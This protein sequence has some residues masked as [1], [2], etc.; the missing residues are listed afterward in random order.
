MAFCDFVL[1][2]SSADSIL[3]GHQSPV[4]V[5]FWGIAMVS[6]VLLAVVLLL[7]V[8]V[9][10]TPW[11]YTDLSIPEQPANDAGFEAHERARQLAAHRAEAEFWNQ[12]ALEA[13]DEETRAVADNLAVHHQMR[14]KILTFQ[15]EDDNPRRPARHGH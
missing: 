2:I 3:D 1:R 11:R 15:S 7:L 5:E 13:T 12:R 6:M 4:S 14:A 9:A 8:W 10:C